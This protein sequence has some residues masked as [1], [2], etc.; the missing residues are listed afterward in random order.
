MFRDNR[1]DALVMKRESLVMEDL[2]KPPGSTC[3]PERVPRGFVSLD[4]AT[5]PASLLLPAASASTTSSNSSSGAHDHEDET[6]IVVILPGLT[7][8]SSSGYV[9]RIALELLLNFNRSF[10]APLNFSSAP[11]QSSS[12]PTTRTRSS[13]SSASASSSAS[14]SSSGLTSSSSS[15]GRLRE[16]LLVSTNIRVACYNPRGRGGN[17]VET[18]FLYSAGLSVSA[19]A[20]SLVSLSR[21][22]SCGLS[23]SL[24]RSLC[25]LSLCLGLSVAVYLSICLGLSLSRSL[26]LG[27]S[28]LDSLSRS[29]CLGLSGLDSL[30]RSLWLGLSCLGLSGLVS[31]VSV[32]LSLSTF[33]IIV[34]SSCERLRFGHGFSLTNIRSV[35]GSAS[36]TS[37]R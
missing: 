9:R 24:S 10:S 12:T 27:L 4:W 35:M 1:M 20:L 13:S 32:C 16:K 30:S 29:L 22:L 25:L 36:S 31:L 23:V 34:G 33:V 5:L 26:C 3:C 6:P 21:S 18:P 17:T 37:A 15:H 11:T 2:E 7:G 19:L 8:S 14:S 28:G